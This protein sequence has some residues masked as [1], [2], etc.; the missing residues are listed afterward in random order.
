MGEYKTA[1]IGNREITYFHEDNPRGEPLIFLHGFGVPPE[2]YESLLGKLGKNHDVIA[3]IAYG[4]NCFE[5]QPTTIG[6]YADLT[7]DFS[8]E[9]GLDKTHL[10]GH[11][12]GGTVAIVAGSQND[13]T[14]D[15]VAM[16]PTFP[17]DYGVTGFGLRAMYKGAREILG[18]DGEED[19]TKFGLA[20]PIPFGV[21]MIKDLG[22]SYKLIK[23]ICDFD[24]KEINTDQ[25]MLI[26]YGEKDEYFKLDKENKDLIKQA[27]PKAR[28][29]RLPKGN[30]DLPILCPDQVEDKINQFIARVKNSEYV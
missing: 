9:L 21:N 8:K 30:H 3:P 28:F 2:H 6:E 22:S 5:P 4:I 11:S 24:Y 13:S 15:I 23:N 25:P 12:M 19:S 7:S 26:L 10:V 27:A 29:E 16:N 14:S 18:V 20:I 1:M 17:V